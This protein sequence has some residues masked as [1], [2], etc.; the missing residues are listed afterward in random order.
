MSIQSSPRLIASFKTFSRAAAAI[1]VTVGCLVLIGWLFDIAVLRSIL[2]HP[3]VMK[4]NSAV[5]FVLF[6]LALW[7]LQEDQ[8]HRQR[9]FGQVLATGVFIFALLTLVEYLSGWSFQIDQLL[10]KATTTTPVTSSLG[11]MSSISALNFT[12]LASALLLLHWKSS[13]NQFPSE[14]LALVAMLFGMVGFL[15]VVLVPSI[16]YTGISLVSALTFMLCSIGVIASH[17]NRGLAA[18]I[19]G[20][21]LAGSVSRRLLPVAVGGPLVV[22]WLA[23]KGTRAGLYGEWFAIALS[24]LVT[25]TMLV[26]FIIYTAHFLERSEESL[27]ASQKRLEGIVNS[28]KDAIVTI[29]A[30]H[31]IVLF[32]PAAE[33]V[34]GYSHAEILGQP[35]D[36][37]IPEQFRAVHDDYIHGFAKTGV[38][39]RSMG[40]LGS[41]SGLHSSGREISIEASISQVEIA[42]QKL[43]T[44]ILRDITVQKQVQEEQERFFTLSLDILCILDDEARFLRLNPAIEKVLGFSPQGLIGQSALD[45]LHPDDLADSKQALEQLSGG[46]PI[47]D[48]VN[49]F[50]C[51]DGSYKNILWT[52]APYGDHLY[53]AGR[54]IT[55][56]VAAEKAV[57]ESE[58][59]FSAA[60]RSSSLALVIATLDGRFVEVNQAFCDLVGY[61]REEMIGKSAIETGILTVQAREKLVA[62]IDEAGGLVNDLELQF[63]MRDGNLRDVVYSVTP[64]TLS[65]VEHRLFSGLDITER[66][67]AEDSLHRIEERLRIVTEN[68]R[69]GL[70]IVNSDR[71]YTF[72]N[73]AYTEML[74]LQPQDIVG[75]QVAEVLAP[76][77]KDQIQPHLDRA[78]A[79]ERVAYELHRAIR[80]EDHY[81]AVRYEPTRTNDEISLVVVVITDITDHKRAEEVIRESATR[82]AGIVNAAMDAIITIDA[83]QRIT[84]FN[85]AAELMF[86]Y[87]GAD[88][89]GHSIECLIPEQF[90]AMHGEHV[91]VFGQ[92]G[93]T[94]RKMG[95]LGVLSGLRANGEEFP[96]EASISQIEIGGQKLFTVILRDITERKQAELALQH[97]NDRLEARV[98]ER[99]AEIQEINES[100]RLEV[101]ERKMAMSALH[102]A[103]E[104]V[105]ATQQMLQLVMNHIPQAIFWKN[106][107][108]VYLGANR[109]L[110][111]DAGFDSPEELIGKNDLDMPWAEYAA[112]YLADDMQVM[113]AD[114]P[115]LN[116]EEALRNA[117]GDMIWLRTNKIP[118]HDSENHVVGVL[119]S[120]EDITEAKQ[121]EAEINEA[122]REAEAANLAKSEFLSRMS[123]ELRTPLNAILGFGQVLEMDDMPPKRKASVQHILKAG[124]HLLDLI[125][126]VLDISRIEAGE[127]RLSLEPVP[128][129]LAVLEVLDLVRLQAASDNIELISEI[130]THSDWHVL[131]DRQRLKQGLLNLF[132]NAIKYNRS[133]GSVRIFAELKEQDKAL[134]LSVR[135]T[136]MGISEHDILKLFTPFERLGAA[137]TRIEG[138]GIGLALTKRLIEAMDGQIGVQSIPGQG[139]TFWIE[140]TLVPSPLKSAQGQSEEA[141]SQAPVVLDSERRTVLYIEDNLANLQLIETLLESRPHIRLLTAMQASTG[142][143]LAYEH[144]PD[145]ILLDLHLPDFNGDEVLRRLQSNPVTGLIPVIIISADATPGQIERL[146]AIGAKAYLTKPFN[147]KQLLRTME[148]NL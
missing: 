34:F 31:R 91:R 12:L 86:G 95:A 100:L 128:V 139:S 24:A 145:L 55:E 110:A 122:K 70:V 136:G 18:I 9:R 5:C 104:A 144:Q 106:R 54:D 99:T 124:T 117:E 80:G 111:L 35:I 146:L 42:G 74:E 4:P 14:C 10:F 46:Q 71:C 141:L 129:N 59:T 28:A 120:Y 85:P 138:T 37:L 89:L 78:F 8:P 93:M 38:T 105:H 142:L 148:E 47:V 125:N 22:A 102:E 101:I 56:R 108:S 132:S 45:Y 135:D 147:V 133:N 66:K 73:A 49:R 134:R 116:I 90:R 112:G 115:K 114:T 92:S 29:D 77:Y 40:G 43:F 60:F 137:L 50:R 84:L 88:L 2:P 97:A 25:I 63:R 16:S 103:A 20:Y 19:G 41:I 53:A 76:M 64:V 69:V 75:R 67:Q 68:A 17:P 119:C 30:A 57:R 13:R 26:V 39:S 109:R 15:D 72:A 58:E 36:R 33:Q 126:E 87:A 82:V 140:L 123:H 27:R 61:A 96:I 48:Y 98:E 131:A 65:G 51:L 107:D 3:V 32:N 113:E 83:E 52:A 94:S 127:L 62:A 7:F 81:Y 143:D 121:A 11:R 44:V 79:G 1:A 6:G 21:G 23:W 118:L 130:P